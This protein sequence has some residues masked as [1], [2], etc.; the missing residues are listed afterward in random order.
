MTTPPDIENL[1]FSL[2]TLAITMPLE[3]IKAKTITGLDLLDFDKRNYTRWSESA[4]DAF[5]YAGI[6]EYVLGE[7][8][9]PAAAHSDLAAWTKNDNLAQAGIRMN[10]A[11]GERD[12]LRD[13]CTI[14]SA[15]DL[16]LELKKRHRAKASTQTALLD[17]LLGVR[18]ER[19]AEMVDS[20][21]KVRDV[22]KQVFEAGALDADKLAL[23][24]L[25][26]SL[27]PELRHIRDKYE[28]DDT[29]KPSDI[30]KSLEKEKLRWEEEGKQKSADERANAARVQKTPQAKT[31]ATTKGL[32][33]TCSGKHRTDECW[34]EGG[35]MEGRRNEVLERRAARRKDNKSA[36]TPAP[37]AGANTSATPPAKPRFAMKECE[38]EEET[39]GGI[40]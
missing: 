18:I 38:V 25:L 13:H 20:A 14:N 31:T 35:A 4:L 29:A 40:C 11:P 32:C 24:V 23:A 22:S 5:L 37:S 28:D 17:D 1:T 19:G 15:H 10:I 16:W 39:W 34:G 2:S 9:R 36:A 30:V 33:G 8:S 6:R 26:R 21:G 27:S 7:V 3:V 12:Y